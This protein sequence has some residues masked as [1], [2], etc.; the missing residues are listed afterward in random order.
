M[1]ISY[2]WLSEYIDHG[3]TPSDLA[4]SLTMSGLEVEQVKQ[5]HL[6]LDGVIVGHV[7]SVNPHPNA[8][9]LQLCQVDLGN[10]KSVQIVCGAPNIEMNQRVPVATIGTRLSVNGKIL[11]IKKNKI[12]GQESVGMICAEDELGLSDDH[13]GIMVLTGTSTIG[14][15]LKEYLHREHNMTSDTSFDLAITPNRPDA[16]CHI[17]VARDL[18]AL[19]NIPLKFP[20]VTLPITG[21]ET[22]EYID[23]EIQCPDT[24]A[25]YTAMII[26]GVRV[27]DSPTWLKRRIESVGLRPINNIVDVTNFVMYECGQPL[28]AF[29]YDQIAQKKIVVRESVSGEKFVTLDGKQ[30]SLDD[31]IVLICDGEHPVAL[32]GIMGGKN[33]EVS[34]STI[35]ILIESAWFNSSRTRRSAKA[36]GISTDASYRFERGVDTALQPWAAMRAAQ[37]ISELGGGKIISGIVDVN[38]TPESVQTVDLRYS[39][40]H[41]ILGIEIK[42]SRV[43]QILDSLGFQPQE[44]EG[45]IISCTVPTYRPDIQIEIDL[46]EE[47]VRIY[48]LENIELHQHSTLQLPAPLPRSDD[49]LCEYAHAYL[50][51]HGFHEIYTNS[52][53]PNDLADQFSHEVLGTNSPLV[54]TLNA[55]SSSM[56]TLRPSLLPG[57]LMVMKHNTHH[58]QRVLR[59][60]EFGHLFHQGTDQAAFI[61]NYTEYEGLLLGVSGPA[62]PGGWDGSSR[63]TDFFDLKGEICQF[64]DILRLSNNLEMEFNDQP[65]EITEYHITL[66]TNQIRAGIIAKLSETIR[67]SYDLPD[68]VFFAE[69]NWS[70]LIRLY[71]RT[72][73][74]TYTSISLFPVVERDL[75]VSVDRSQPVGPMIAA[76]QKA[77]KPLLQDV[78]I[79]D[80]Y[81]GE[82]IHK[83]QKSVAFA[84]RFAADR[85]LRDQEINQVMEKIVNAL[86]EQFDANLRK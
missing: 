22:A 43:I 48:G 2:N 46:I 73:N 53:L 67:E 1:N 45:R 40:I 6:S 44:K 17:G 54:H 29:D 25:R 75:A 18:S 37:L 3:L 36:L 70:S 81:T 7:Q 10:H 11:K 47:I 82:H 62:Q 32:G 50:T 69:F 38:P 84:L 13:S 63:I 60:Y 26:Q 66:H 28:H 21:G 86:S 4:D 24:C 59:F 41:K 31:G 19:R 55:A 57:M 52:L 56:A 72:P 78:N 65:S 51:G 68:P 58:S 30:H 85:T 5:N 9:R 34:D 14:E 27:A 16:T 15:P 64:L 76:L 79:F 35:N 12:R 39:R 23:V 20:E 33:S 71:E 80:L 77:G 74:S 61:E 49:Q 8:D 83:E 42:Y